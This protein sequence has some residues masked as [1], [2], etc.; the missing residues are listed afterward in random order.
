LKNNYL[1]NRKGERKVN[2]TAL[3]ALALLVAES[4]PVQK[5]VMV[6]LIVNLINRK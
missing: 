2:D 1:H 6:K 4:K 5:E 3:I